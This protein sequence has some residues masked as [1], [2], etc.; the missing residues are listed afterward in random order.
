MARGH[1]ELL[2]VDAPKLSSGRSFGYSLGII[3]AAIGAWLLWSG[4]RE[5][6]LALLAAAAVL[7]GLAA[8]APRALEPLN[9][10]WFRFGLLI[11][12]VM[13]PVILSLLFATVIVP[14]GWAARGF[15]WLQIRLKPGERDSYW[16][17]RTPAGPARGSMKNQ[18]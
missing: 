18:F 11:A 2:L 15:G 17:A 1:H 3:L 7:A 10:V 9:R 6:G 4:N 12:R 14:A 8:L 13:N 16:V 5:P